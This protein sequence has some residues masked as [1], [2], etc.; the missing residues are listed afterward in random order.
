MRNINT[1]KLV[2]TILFFGIFFAGCTFK[3]EVDSRL[4]RGHSGNSTYDS[5]RV[6]VL[7]G[8]TNEN[9]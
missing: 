3:A 6:T 5:T 4:I 1:L 2:V 8:C 7:D 9:R